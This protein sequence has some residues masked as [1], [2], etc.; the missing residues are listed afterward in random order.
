MSTLSDSEKN[1][2]A[3]VSPFGNVSTNEYVSILPY[4]E[5]GDC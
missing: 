3:D 4:P 5:T 2:L 1:V